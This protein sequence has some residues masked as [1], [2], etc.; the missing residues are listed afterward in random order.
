M[1]A[2]SA[3]SP[4]PSAT[5]QGERPC[6]VCGT[7]TLEH[8]LSGEDRLTGAPGEFAV[9]RCAECALAFTTPRIGPD[10]FDL[11]YPSDYSNH[12]EASGSSSRVSRAHQWGIVHRGPYRS[13]ARRRPGRM[14]DVG[15][16]RGELASAFVAA[17]WRTSGVEPSAHAAAQ[18]L[19]AG[20]DVHVGELDDAPWPESSFDA[21]TFNHSLEHIPDPLGALE[22]AHALLRPGGAVAISVPNFGCWQRRAFGTHWFQLDLPRH[23]QHFEHRSLEE[24]VSRAGFRVKARGTTPMRAGLPNS[25]Q[26]RL[27]GRLRFAG[28]GYR[29]LL[30]LMLP[31]LRPLDAIGQGDCL[32][33]VAC[34]D[35]A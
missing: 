6:P 16:G 13:L 7:D 35:A 23:L 28:G 15:C 24:L 10:Q 5:R 2:S 11:Y 27:F 25:L 9:V 30:W 3:I 12:V 33:V 34:R 14:L 19:T 18:A 29:K 17:G 1:A 26:Y 32:Y 8:V 20:I 4:L 21:I 31:L 22:S